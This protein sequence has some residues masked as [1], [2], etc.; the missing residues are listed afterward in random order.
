[1]DW[2]ERL[3]QFIE[4][5]YN[6]TR[7]RLAVEGSEMRSPA[8]ATGLDGSRLALFKDCRRVF[9]TAHNPH[10]R[11]SGGVLA[12]EP[13]PSHPATTSTSIPSAHNIS[14]AMTLAPP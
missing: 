3:S 8:A 14:A 12:G 2:F 1:M 13:G 6:E 11:S 10:D 7:T 5:D 9:R 4:T